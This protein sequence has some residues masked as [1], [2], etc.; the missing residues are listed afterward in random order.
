MILVGSYVEI[1]QVVLSEHE[2]ASNIP[3]DTKA[4]PLKMWAKGWL[5]QDA[6]EGSTALVRTINGRILEG[7]ITEVNPAYSHDYGELIPEVLLIGAQA[8]RILWGDEVEQV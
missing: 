2:R 8:K 5:L 7:I 4:T 1:M 6:V 3:E